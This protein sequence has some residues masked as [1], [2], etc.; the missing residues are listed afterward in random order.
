MKKIKEI[1]IG[2]NN[3]GK[4][5]ELCDLL[6]I[7]IKK[8]SPKEF[9]LSSPQENGKSFEENAMIKARYFSKKT[10]LICLSDDSGLEVDILN[11]SPGIYSARWGGKKA[12]FNLAIKKVLKKI[13]K[14]NK[15]WE[16]KNS[17]KFTCCL[18]LYFPNGTKYLSTGIVRGNISNKKKGKKGF[19]YDPIFIPKGYKKTF[20]EMSPKLKV[21]I[22]H[23][24]KAFLKIKKYFS[25]KS[26]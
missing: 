14:F 3:E 21:S 23:R 4:Y 8:Y 10:N 12:N 15:K 20:G 19:G 26:Q 16:Y 22:D 11:G 7:G 2:T 18:A 1:I 24:F 17:A 25:N 5:R 6:P 13:S 9:N